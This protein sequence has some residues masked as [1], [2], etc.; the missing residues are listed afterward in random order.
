[1]ATNSLNHHEEYQNFTNQLIQYK[2][3]QE[4]CKSRLGQTDTRNEQIPNKGDHQS[5]GYFKFTEMLN[6]SNFDH[7]AQSQLIKQNNQLDGGPNPASNNPHLKNVYINRENKKQQRPSS[8][9]NMQ[10]NIKSMPIQQQQIRY[11]NAVNKPNAAMRTQQTKQVS[12][13]QKA[14]FHDIEQN[15]AVALPNSCNTTQKMQMQY[16]NSQNPKAVNIN[17][18]RLSLNSIG[19]QNQNLINM[20]FQETGPLHKNS[21]TATNMSIGTKKVKVIKNNKQTR[22][23]SRS[24]Q[25]HVA[26]PNDD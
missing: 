5:H 7:F 6:S 11:I 26:P 22:D 9:T 10:P 2:T 24:S 21:G 15:Q 17:Q 3:N 4:I 25:H 23:Q 20:A 19:S 1:M 12:Q 13:K 18:K 16:L 14:L 8:S